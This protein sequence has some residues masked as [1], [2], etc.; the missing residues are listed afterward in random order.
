MNNKAKTKEE[1]KDVEVIG[2]H[3]QEGREPTTRR[4]KM[5]TTRNA[6]EPTTKKAKDLW[7]RRPRSPQL[8]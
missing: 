7:P 8:G 1:A 4:T 2:T 3:N 5:H 6:K